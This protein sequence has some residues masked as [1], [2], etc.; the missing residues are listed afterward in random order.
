MPIIFLGGQVGDG[1]AGLAHQLLRLVILMNAGKNHTVIAGA[2][3]QQEFQQLL[4]LLHRLAG[5]DLH[6][7]EVGL[8]EGVKIHKVGKQRLNLHLGEVNNLCCHGSGNGSSLLRL[9]FSL[10]RLG[11]IGGLHGGDKI[12]HME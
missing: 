12:P 7:S 9:F 2:V 6:H 3:I 8:G 10:F 5:L 1:N 4:G 11:Q